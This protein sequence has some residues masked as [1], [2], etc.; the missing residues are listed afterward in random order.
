MRCLRVPSDSTVLVDGTWAG[1]GSG[2]VAR[3]KAAGAEAIAGVGVASA[4]LAEGVVDLCAGIV[5]E[6][7]TMATLR[8]AAT[9][10]G[11]DGEGKGGGG[12]SA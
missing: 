11:V 3:A 12:V 9:L 7:G 10:T 1:S 4:V 2:V 5:T 8:L 6:L